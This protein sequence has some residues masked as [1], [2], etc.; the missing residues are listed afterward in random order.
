MQTVTA[1]DPNDAVTF[2]LTGGADLGTVTNFL[3]VLQVARTTDDV[4][5]VDGDLDVK[6]APYTVKFS[7]NVWVGMPTFKIV[8]G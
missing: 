1:N 7:R 8:F 5:T 2:N 6:V 3:G 4:I